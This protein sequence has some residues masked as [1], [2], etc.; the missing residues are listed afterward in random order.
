V[1]L[2][3]IRYGIENLHDAT[4][5]RSGAILAGALLT[6]RSDETLGQLCNEVGHAIT[7]HNAVKD[8]TVG[9]ALSAIRHAVM[10]PEA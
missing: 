6:R 10:V 3:S 4:P 7:T 9:D 1:E 5:I 8:Q 2:F